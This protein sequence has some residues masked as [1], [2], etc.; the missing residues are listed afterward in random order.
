MVFELSSIDTT[1]GVAG[2]ALGLMAGSR[3]IMDLLDDCARAAAMSRGRNNASLNA[4][5]NAAITILRHATIPLLFYHALLCMP[6]SRLHGWM[7]CQLPLP[8]RAPDCCQ[9][10]SIAKQVSSC[11]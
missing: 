8:H 1:F 7:L 6:D 11:T 2:E 5:E 9:L 3:I 10:L 4:V